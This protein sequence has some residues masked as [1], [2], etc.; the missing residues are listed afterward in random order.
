MSISHSHEVKFQNH[1]R[2]RVTKSLYLGDDSSF[3]GDTSGD[4]LPRISKAA[5]ALD[6]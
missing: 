4:K 6:G 5:P 1:K 3:V 2:A